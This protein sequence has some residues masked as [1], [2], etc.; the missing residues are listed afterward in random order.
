MRTR[1]ALFILLLALVALTGLPVAAQD[2]TF[3]SNIDPNTDTPVE[4][5]FGSPYYGNL[6]VANGGVSLFNPPQT[7]GTIDNT[8]N[9][10]PLVINQCAD[11]NFPIIRG[12]FLNWYTRWRGTSG[13]PPTFDTQIN[14][15]INSSSVVSDVPP[16][17]LFL[18]R[19]GDNR[20]RVHGIVDVTSLLSS[21]IADGVNS[22]TVSGLDVPTP[23][24]DQNQHYG[25]GITAIYE[26][27]EF[28]YVKVSYKAGLDW[29]YDTENVQ[30]DVDMGEVSGIICEELPP[31]ASSVSLDSV[32]GGQANATSPFRPHALYILGS[33]APPPAPADGTTLP[34]KY[35]DLA[36]PP[37]LLETLTNN[38]WTSSAGQEWDVFNYFID[39]NDSYDYVCI[40]AESLGSSIGIS[41]DLLS[42]VFTSEIPVVNLGDYVWIDANQDGIQGSTT[43]EPPL[44]GALVELFLPNGDPARLPSGELVPSQ[45]TNSNGNYNF[46]NLSPGDYVVRVTPPSGYLPTPVNT[47]NPE[48]GV[49][50]DS[51]IDIN[52]NPPSGSYESGV[53]SLAVGDE[54]GDD[55]DG[56]DG[57]LTVDFGFYLPAEEPEYDLALRKTV[58]SQS[59]TATPSGQ[60]IE[61][62]FSIEVFNQGD[63]DASDIQITDYILPSMFEPFDP[64]LNP[65]GSTTGSANLPYTWSTAGGNAIATLTGTLP[66][67]GSVRFPITLVVA[68]GAG[69]RIDNFAE[70][71]SDDGDDVD[72]TPDGNNDEYDPNNPDTDRL[73]DDEIFNFFNDEDDHDI[74]SITLEEVY[75]LALIKTTGASVVSPG[76]TV[77]FTITVR[78]QGTAD[79]GGITVTDYV[80]T[81]MFEAFDTALNPGGTT[82]GDI[83]LSYTWSAAGVATITGTLPAQQEL[84]LPVT[85]RVLD[86]VEDG[87]T[88]VNYAEISTD[89][90]DDRD[91][92]PDSTNEEPGENRVQDDRIDLPSDQDEDD[93]DIAEIVVSTRTTYS[94]GNYVWSDDDNSGHVNDSETGIGG[95]LLELLDAS[96]NVLQTTTSDANGYYL[97]DDLAA[98]DYRV[99]IAA[100]N[101]SGVLEGYGPSTGALEESDPDS[102]GDQNDNGD[103]PSNPAATGITSGVFTLGDGEPTGETP[104]ASGIN[105]NDGVGTPDVNSNLTVDFG[106][107]P[108]ETIPIPGPSVSDPA[109]VKLVDPAF[110]LPGED[111]VWTVTISNPNSVALTGVQIE[112]DIPAELTILSAT[113]SGGITSISG[114]TVTVSI[115][116]LAPGTSV[117]TTI[118]T[119]IR[120]SVAPP[121]IIENVAVIQPPYTGSSSARVLSAQTLPET[122][123]APAWRMPLLVIL[124]SALLLLVTVREIQK[125]D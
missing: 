26:C 32:F 90:G 124:I 101:F 112:D 37:T 59:V 49:N 86:S 99:R 61:V 119:R 89:D 67:G 72:S 115:P 76:E 25:I 60:T 56:T 114:Q 83:T 113:S 77:T 53:V 98:G 51:N 52:R 24:A 123:E 13:G 41:G 16:D 2:Y 5:R 22:V 84:T 44:Q 81:S 43:D 96:G 106:V 108:S 97:F 110:A 80:D 35:T 19:V 11:G 10:Q 31:N 39:L 120:D 17:E 95:V 34:T 125:P 18:A 91:S 1:A 111:V 15:Q 105:G 68:D 102:D 69:G 118:E 73:T 103:N 85:L 87:D 74:A 122:G 82:G 30:T 42:P 107:V 7:G 121:Y 20:Y 4:D 116:V 46:R 70:I 66:A 94:I 117:Q 54:P 58:E 75:D 28:P 88:L 100:S 93:H 29:F 45:T 6:S 57:N 38:V 104:T 47:D 9:S 55:G 78:N 50:T 71:S 3:P 65:D 23:L 33:A 63:V 14:I 40:Q 48:D 21:N 8:G 64:A 79:A 36:T 92:T 109:I 62:T 27:P 12:A